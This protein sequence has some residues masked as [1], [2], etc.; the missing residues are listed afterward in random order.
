VRV[1]DVLVRDGGQAFVARADFMHAPLLV[2]EGGAIGQVRR[3]QVLG[4]LQ[5]I[6]RD[7]RRRRCST[8]GCTQ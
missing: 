4:P 1:L 3:W 7:G 6:Q 8:R 5:V 2:K